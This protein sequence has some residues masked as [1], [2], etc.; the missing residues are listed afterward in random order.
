VQGR[1]AEIRIDRQ[2]VFHRAMDVR[3]HRIQRVARREVLDDGGGTGFANKIGGAQ[4]SALQSWLNERPRGQRQQF[5][6]AVARDDVLWPAAMQLRQLFPQ[7]FRRRIRIQPQPAIHRRLDRRPHLRRRGIRILVGVKLDQ[8]FDLRLLARCIGVQLAHQ[9]T[10]QLC[11]AHE[12]N[13]NY[14]KIFQLFKAYGGNGNEHD[15][16]MRMSRPCGLPP[17]CPDLPPYSFSWDSF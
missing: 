10:D 12:F 7:S 15:T 17:K 6:R 8:A 16:E 11:F 2:G 9:R 3:Q 5:I 1:Q 4:D 13:S 14:K